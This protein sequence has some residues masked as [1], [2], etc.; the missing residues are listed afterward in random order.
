MTAPPREFDRTDDDGII[1]PVELTGPLATLIHE[2]LP[3]L[4]ADYGCPLRWSDEF[5][6]LKVALIAA[7]QGAPRPMAKVPP[8]RT[9]TTD[10]AATMI[11]V[12]PS[13]IRRMMQAGRIPDVVVTEHG[14][15]I[16]E[17]WVIDEVDRRD[18]SRT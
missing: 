1:V 7:A 11:G 3:R 12:N 4:A 5:H 18:R 17:R 15:R 13:T 16:P 6:S 8:R 10:E 2:A 9:V 14:R